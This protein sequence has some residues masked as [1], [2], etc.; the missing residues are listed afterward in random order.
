M[1]AAQNGPISSNTLKKRATLQAL[2]AH[3][4]AH[5]VAQTA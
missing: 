4:A 5:L 3:L 1:P 2:V